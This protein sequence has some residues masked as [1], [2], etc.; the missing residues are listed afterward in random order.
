M[1]ILNKKP[2]AIVDGAKIEEILTRGVERIYPSAGFLEKRLKSGER[3][4]LYLGID[5]TGPTLHFGH[6]I[7]LLKLR[8]FQEL[9]HKIIL[10]IGDFTGMVG[11]PTDKSST[12]KQLSNEE[13]YANQLCYKEQAARI[14]S[15]KGENPATIQ[16]NSRWLGKMNL[17]DVIGLSAN[18][19]H[20]QVIKRDMFQERIKEGKDLY[21]H[22]F[23][24]PLMQGYDSVAMDVDGEVGGNDQTFN[25]L[26]GRDLMK[27]LKNKEK[28][29]L[30]LKLL[31][32]P[33]GKKMGKTEGN[34]AAFS[35][36]PGEMFG[37]VMSWSD[38]MIIP[39]FELCTTIPL[40]EVEAMK[41][42]L[43]GGTNPKEIKLKLAEAIVSL[44]Y[45]GAEA[46]KTRISFDATF[47]AREAPRDVQVIRATEHE[48]LIDV[49]V[50]TGIVI[51]KSEFRRLLEDGAISQYESGEKIIADTFPAKKGTYRIGK[52]RFVKIER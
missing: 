27:K 44:L 37:K 3:L 21:L 38:S 50:K 43:E 17:I 24:Y 8:Q 45:S 13:V 25:M 41:R 42:E 49:V 48:L 47:T 40:A 28:F 36:A 16:H 10:L 14:I 2:S 9:G 39:G 12:R 31:V 19:T 20:A 7:P 32:D 30:A 35:D 4:S 15:F 26:V 52:H 6:M 46:K 1:S 22:E 11:D 5:P 23:L 34:M 33:T 51:S 29:V 18:L